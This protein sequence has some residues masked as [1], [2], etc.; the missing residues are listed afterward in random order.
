MPH[1]RVLSVAVLLVALSACAST[2]DSEPSSSPSSP[3]ST[4][5]SQRAD[6][7]SGTAARGE[8][9]QP[10][11]PGEANRTLPP[12]TTLQA[13]K[14]NEPDMM[15]VRM[16]VPHHAQ[17]LEMSALARTRAAS[18]EVKALARRIEGAQ[19]PEIQ[20]MTT[21][22]QSRGMDVPQD[23]GDLASHDGHSDHEA[24]GRLMA[25]NGMLTG[26]QMKEL[27]RARGARFDRLFLAGMIQHHRGAIAMANVALRDGRE[28][29]AQELAADI[30][31]S[32]R[33]EIQ[34]MRAIQR[35][36]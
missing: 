11:R 4:A 9:V 7:A 18:D 23:A 5:A 21:W 2:G 8:I 25:M 24:H 32:Q 26:Q 29:Q 20:L 33:A 34:R 17:A 19:G 15:F 6:S 14:A 31:T 12:D 36:L 28:V 22:L 1:S 35:A 30:A 10:G 13:E 27:A 3:S 16:M